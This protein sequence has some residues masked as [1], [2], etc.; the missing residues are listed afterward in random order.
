[1]TVFRLNKLEQIFG[2]VR[3]APKMMLLML[4]STLLLTGK[5]LSIPRMSK[6]KSL[7]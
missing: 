4:F 7:P 6:L 2:D 3:L 5:L 1:M